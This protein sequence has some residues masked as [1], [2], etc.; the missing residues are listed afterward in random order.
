MTGGN[1][2]KEGHDSTKSTCVVVSPHSTKEVG[3][4]AKILKLFEVRF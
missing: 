1:Y 2:I 3:A 4:L